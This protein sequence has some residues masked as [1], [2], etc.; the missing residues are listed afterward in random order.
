[1][2]SALLDQVE[3]SVAVLA[4]GQTIAVPSRSDYVRFLVAGGH[5]GSESELVGTP[6]LVEAVYRHWQ[7]KPQLACVFA[8]KMVARPADYGFRTHVL[9]GGATVDGSEELARETARLVKIA[10]EDEA[11]EAV[12][13]VAPE[14]DS[15]DALVGFCMAL[16]QF[17]GWTHRA[18]ANP[19]DRLGRVHVEL[20]YE[21]DANVLSEVLGF[22]PLD[23]L[24]LT[25]RAPFTG[26]ELR[27]KAG[28]ALRVKKGPS[29]RRKVHLAAMSF[30]PEDGDF[31]ETWTRTEQAR[32]DV[33]G[34]DDSAARARITYAIP[35][36]YWRAQQ[37]DTILG[38]TE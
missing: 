12:S 8:R 18:I 24:P 7:T 33:L 2:D 27:A 22:A 10:C 35:A 11:V 31:L 28:G 15:A 5:V 38:D 34:G 20:K 1:M 21:L 23:F 29:Q 14:V 25:R 32:V 17:S 6:E 19:S 37:P 26:I 13:I 30:R 9:P 16:G 4:E 36:D 3:G